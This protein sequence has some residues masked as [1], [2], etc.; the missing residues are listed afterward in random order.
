[1]AAGVTERLWEMVDAIVDVLDA[2]EAKEKRDA[3][4]LF[5]VC[6]VKIGGGFYVRAALPN[7]APEQIYGFAT[8]ADANRWIR[9]EFRGL[10]ECTQRSVFIA[11]RAH[12]S[13][14]NSRSFSRYS[15]CSTLKT[16]V[17]H[18]MWPP[19]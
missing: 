5:D 12:E 3:R 19:R 14:P 10:V 8:E 6:E 11:W 4:P 13:R 18:R 2:W 1:M 7:A 9:N 15:Q 17:D 16:A